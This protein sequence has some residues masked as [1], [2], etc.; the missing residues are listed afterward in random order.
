MTINAGYVQNALTLAQPGS[1]LFRYIA[2]MAAVEYEKGMAIHTSR[3][4]VLSTPSGS[5]QFTYF[6]PI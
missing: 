6:C 4:T 2:K 3:L 1:T 5:F